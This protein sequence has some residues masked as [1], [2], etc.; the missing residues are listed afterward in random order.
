MWLS[1]GRHPWAV[2]GG[3]GKRKHPKAEVSLHYVRKSRGGPVTVAEVSFVYLRKS[4]GWGVA[5]WLRRKWALCTWG[6]AGG[7]PCDLI[8]LEYGDPRAEAMGETVKG[9]MDPCE[10]FGSHSEWNGEPLE[11][12]GPR[13]NMMLLIFSNTHFGCWIE[14]NWKAASPEGRKSDSR[15]LWQPE[16]TWMILIWMKVRRLEMVW[17]GQILICFGGRISQ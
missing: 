16:R 1:S 12:F 6:R 10:H 13:I 3:D 2:G 7:D 14:N 4:E 5:L 8:E 11:R 15:L 9:L 17:R